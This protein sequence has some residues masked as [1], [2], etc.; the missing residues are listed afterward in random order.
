[1]DLSCHFDVLKKESQT[2]AALVGFFSFLFFLLIFLWP[3]W[4]L[5]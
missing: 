1:M 3:S 4:V 5:D 2:V